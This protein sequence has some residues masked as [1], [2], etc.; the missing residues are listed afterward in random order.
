MQN[1]KYFEEKFNRVFDKLDTVNSNIDKLDV[2]IKCIE[3]NMKGIEDELME[4]R[5]LK[6]YPKLSV[7][8]VF[9]TGF[10]FIASFLY[11]LL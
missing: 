10:I 1:D 9:I 6:K 3:T 8:I 4:Y 5:F 7:L 11:K 2:K